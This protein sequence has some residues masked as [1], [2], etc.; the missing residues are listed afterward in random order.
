MPARRYPWPMPFGIGVPELL[1][2]LVILLIVMGP[3]RLPG[4]G[5]SLGT[6]MREFRDS[7]AG[8]GSADDADDEPPAIEAAAPAPA[9]ER[10][11]A[12]TDG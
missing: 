1:I 5:K 3:K 7:I 8:K 12:R 4:I 9:D 2:I 6:G 11:R 10:T